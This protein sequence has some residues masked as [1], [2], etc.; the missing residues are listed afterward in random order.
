M[1][2][3]VAIGPD[4]H[5]AVTSSSANSRSNP[6]ATSCALLMRMSTVPNADT[7]AATQRSMSASTFTSPATTM[8]APPRW[9]ISSRTEI[10]LLSVRPISV[11]EAPAE[12]S[13]RA[14]P[15]PTPCPAPVTMA[16]LPASGLCSDIIGLR[17]HTTKDGTQMKFDHPIIDTDGHLLEV[18]PHVAEYV[19]DIGGPVVAD[20]FVAKHS[21][22][23]TPI[24]G[25]ALAWWA[26]PRDALDR[27]TSFVPKLLYDR[28][29]EL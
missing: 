9:S 26:T 21:Q 6:N 23:F 15:R 3:K 28:L 7:V 13:A 25:N 24:G 22:G 2:R 1:K 27:A 16:A 10:S 18:I 11:N 5:P 4:S 14:T 20:R 12:A 19:R 29:P 8:A 17:S